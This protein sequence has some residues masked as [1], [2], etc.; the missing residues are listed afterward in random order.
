MDLSQNFFNKMEL[1]YQQFQE[2]DATQTDRLN[3]YRNIETESAKLLNILLRIQQ[4]KRILEIGTS[5]GYSTL[6]LAEAAKSLNAKIT[7]LEIDNDRT[8]Q[9]K[10]YAEEFEF[11]H[12]IEFR[13][14]DAVEYLSHS[15]EVFD[16]ILLDAERDAYCEYWK[17]LPDLIRNNGGVLVVDNVISHQ[18]EVENFIKLVQEDS[19]FITTTL[20]VGAGLFLVT[21]I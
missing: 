19:Q 18:L 13:V 6:W 20:N 2:H 7:T 3:R 11:S 10:S 8:Q 21:K 17:Y 4:S 16:F 1:L 14:M 9:A 15:Y 5:T 12:L